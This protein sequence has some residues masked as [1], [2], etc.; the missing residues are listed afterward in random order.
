[1][2]AQYA[3]NTTQAKQLLADAG[4]P[5]GFKTDDIVASGVD[6]NLVNIVQSDFADIGVDMSVTTMDAASWN[7]VVYVGKHYDAIAQRA[8]GALG[9]YFYPLLQLTKFLSNNTSNYI[10]VNDPTYD[11][12]YTQAMAA[13]STDEM[14]QIVIDENKYVAGQH[15]VVSLL[16]PMVF[17]LCQPWVIGFNAQ[18]GS[19]YGNSGPNLLGFYYARFWVDE[20]L[21]NSMGH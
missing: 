9:L 1:M 2:K 8:T 16:Q 6:M 12:F 18:Y 11:A 10:M 21:K 20:N 13:T 17:G 5:N 3:Y 15:Y 4:Y 7:S 19:T 14:K